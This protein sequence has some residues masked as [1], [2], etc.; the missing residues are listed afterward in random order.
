MVTIEVHIAFLNTVLKSRAGWECN[1]SYLEFTLGSF[2]RYELDRSVPK[3]QRGS[4]LIR[5][6]F[7]E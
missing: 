7:P 5:V 4:P 1:F 3:R 2:T 6:P